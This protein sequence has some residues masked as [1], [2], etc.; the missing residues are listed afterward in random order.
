[1]ELYK[2]NKQIQAE[3]LLPIDMSLL[4]CSV[5][6]LPP[7]YVPASSCA[8]PVEPSYSAMQ[9]DSLVNWRKWYRPI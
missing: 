5:L 6:G 4:I 7:A 9:T 2:C 3:A 1:M 8:T